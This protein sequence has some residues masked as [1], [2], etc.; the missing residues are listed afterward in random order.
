M[1]DAVVKEQIY[2]GLYRHS[3]DSK[4]RIPIPFRWRQDKSEDSFEFTVMVWRKHQAGTCLRVLP[5]DQL[6][7]FRAAIDA[8][9]NSDLN[10]SV[11]KRSI[12]TTSVQA[13]LDSVGRIT[14]PDEMAEAAGLGNEV[15]LAGMIDRFEI[16]NPARYAKARELDDAHL[17]KALDL[18]E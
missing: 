12:G 10:K 4:R 13:K 5:P 3:A 17:G 9:P 2:N 18:M 6:V 16:W 8:M 14:I 1:A 7:K 11:L 15:V